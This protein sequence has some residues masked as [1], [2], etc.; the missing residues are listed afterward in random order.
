MYMVQH[1]ELTYQQAIQ[2]KYDVCYSVK[3]LLF[4]IFSHRAYY[5]NKL[6]I[7]PTLITPTMNS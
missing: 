7:N 5:V 2:V 1:D 3:T 4:C 6:Y